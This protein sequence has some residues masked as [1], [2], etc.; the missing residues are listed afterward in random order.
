MASMW[1]CLL[2]VLVSVDGTEDCVPLCYDLSLKSS[3]N[4]DQQQ[5]H[6]F[7]STLTIL[8]VLYITISQIL[9]AVHA[10]CFKNVF[11]LSSILF[12]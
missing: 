11:L 6:S 10:L 2:L 1:P 5:V 3:L 12:F 7:Y 8:H 9:Y 4:F